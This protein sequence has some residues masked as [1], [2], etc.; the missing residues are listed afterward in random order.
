MRSATTA[1]V[2]LVVPDLGG[3]RN[4]DFCGGSR[5]DHFLSFRRWWLL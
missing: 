2:R 5:R 1:V 4:F 3:G